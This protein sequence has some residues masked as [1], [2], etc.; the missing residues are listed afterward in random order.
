MLKDD[1]PRG[2]RAYVSARRSLSWSVTSPLPLLPKRASR[3]GRTG[4]AH[5]SHRPAERRWRCKHRG[6][7][8]RQYGRA[9]GQEPVPRDQ[10][11]VIGQHLGPERQALT[12]RHTRAVTDR[13]P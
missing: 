3:Q 12:E 11:H 8:E 4:V 6:C 7:T 13:T 10:L 5:A 9:D 2:N 1:D